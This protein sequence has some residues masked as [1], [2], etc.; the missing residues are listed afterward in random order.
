MYTKTC[1]AGCLLSCDNALYPTNE[2][3]IGRAL[4]YDLWLFW[5]RNIENRNAFCHFLTSS[6]DTSGQMLASSTGMADIARFCAIVQKRCRGQAQRWHHP[7]LQLATQRAAQN[8]LCAATGPV[9]LTRS[10]VSAG[11]HAERAAESEAAS[12]LAVEGDKFSSTG[13]D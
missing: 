9:A 7:P 2:H 6:G 10:G 3:I 8:Q 4:Y 13:T 12:L 1:H 5:Q 11:V